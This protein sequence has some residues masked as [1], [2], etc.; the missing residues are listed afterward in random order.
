MHG[1]LVK[2]CTSTEH[3]SKFAPPPPPVYSFLLHNVETVPDFRNFRVKKYRSAPERA[4]SLPARD[5]S[6]T[7]V[8]DELEER[9]NPD[10]EKHRITRVEYTSV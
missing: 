6:R 9:E 4:A 10:G 5:H 2:L 3:I 7:G 8:R 1:A